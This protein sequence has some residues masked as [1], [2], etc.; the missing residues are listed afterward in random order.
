MVIQFKNLMVVLEFKFAAKSSD[1]RRLKAEGTAQLQ[2]REYTKGYDAEGRK[3]IS[4]VIVADD[5]HRQ[6]VS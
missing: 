3:I 1:V 2:D 4:A 6:V 5:E